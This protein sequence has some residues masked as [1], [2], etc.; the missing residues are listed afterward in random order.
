VPAPIVAVLST[1]RCG[2]QWLAR[3]LG[4]LEPGLWVQ[5]EPIGPLYAPRRHFRRYADPERVFDE[6]AVRR[7]LDGVLASKRTYVECGWPLFPALP[8]L[9]TAVPERLRVIHLS[10]HPVPTALSHMSHSSWA[11]SPRND[12]FTRVATLGPSDPRVFQPGYARRWGGLTPFEKCLFW[13]T[14]VHLFGLEFAER[15]PAVPFVRV[16]A[17]EM[18]AGDPHA[19]A[20]ILE[21]VGAGDVERLRARVGERVDSWSHHTD[22][23]LDPGLVA[24]HPR[25]VATALRLGYDALIYDAEALRARYRGEPERGLDRHGRFTGDQ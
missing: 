4:E 14:E 20:S 18:L 17:E 12:E 3:N 15:F 5:H 9:A 16:R 21:L 13:W 23:E 6:P 1:G 24:Q 2:T 25:T 11:D 22:R 7:H 8:W 10:R 19:L